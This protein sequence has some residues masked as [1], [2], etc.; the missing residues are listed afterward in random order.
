M[1]SL[2]LFVEPL[3][4]CKAHLVKLIAKV[5]IKPV[6]LIELIDA[7]CIKRNLYELYCSLGIFCPENILAV[8]FS[9]RFIF[10]AMTS[11][12]YKLTPF[13]RGRKYFAGL[14]FV[15]EGDGRT[16]FYD[17]FPVYSTY[18]VHLSMVCPTPPPGPGW[19]GIGGLSCL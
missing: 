8:K 6:L 10:I 14:I 2:H 4:C 5:Q 9:P 15:V 11:R 16:F 3:D 12:K 7:E 18:I 13:I 19:G 17:D 1:Y